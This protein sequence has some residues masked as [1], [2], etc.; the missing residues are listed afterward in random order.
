MFCVEDTPAGLVFNQ[1]IILDMS[2]SSAVIWRF[3]SLCH[4][5]YDVV[6]HLIIIIY[7]SIDIYIDIDR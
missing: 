3:L 7:M 6:K 2:F 1:A 5:K 4:G